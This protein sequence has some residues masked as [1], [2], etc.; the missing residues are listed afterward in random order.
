L[1]EGAD[2][3]LKPVVVT[4]PDVPTG[5]LLARFRADAITG[6]ATDSPV[7]TWPSIVGSHVMAATGGPLLKTDGTKKWVETDGVNDH[8]SDDT[9]DRTQPACMVVVAKLVVNGTGKYIVSG[10]SAAF[11]SLGTDA[12]G[13]AN[14]QTYAGTALAATVVSDANWHVF[15]ASVNGASSELMIDGVVARTGNAGALQADGFRIGSSPGLG[16]FSAVGV[17]EAIVYDRLLTTE[18]KASVSATLAAYHGIG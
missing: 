14:F 12:S 4:P 3:W 7:T 9:L 8:L 2:I 11:H 1:I 15:I 17:A 18:E 16:T 5:E 6:V 13:D 10:T